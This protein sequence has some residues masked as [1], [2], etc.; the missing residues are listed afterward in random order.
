MT[1]VK[2]AKSGVNAQT[3]TDPN[4]F[5]FHSDYNTFKIIATGLYEPTV[6]ANSTADYT[7]AHGLEQIPFVL[8][9][10]QE[11]SIA[12]VVMAHNYSPNVTANLKFNYVAADYQYLRFNIQNQHASNNIVAHI[13]YFIM[14]IP[15]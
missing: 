6:I 15:L 7:V 3:A 12:E 8:A 5:I 9:F 2:V 13:R 14:E 11:A 10:M 1:V 4:D